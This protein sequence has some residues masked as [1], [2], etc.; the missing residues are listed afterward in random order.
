MKIVILA[1][2]GAIGVILG[3]C[4]NEI[5]VQSAALQ[6]AS[7]QTEQTEQGEVSRRIKILKATFAGSNVSAVVQ[8]ACDGTSCEL[9]ATEE[10][11][12]KKPAAYGDQNLKVFYT[13][14]HLNDGAFRF[15]QLGPDEIKTISC[16]N[17]EPRPCDNV[18][19]TEWV[20]ETQVVVAP[21]GPEHPSLEIPLSIV[22]AKSMWQLYKSTPYPDKVPAG[23]I[24]VIASPFAGIGA[25]IEF[26]LF[27][28]PKYLIKKFHY[29]LKGQ[30]SRVSLDFDLEGNYKRRWTTMRLNEGEPS[31]YDSMS[32][33]VIKDRKNK[34]DLPIN[35]DLGVPDE[36]MGNG[37]NISCQM[38]E[39]Q[40]G[41]DL[42][43]G[44]AK[45]LPPEGA[46]VMIDR[47]LS[48]EEPLGPFYFSC[49]DIDYNTQ[50]D[51]LRAKCGR[52][53]DLEPITSELVVGDCKHVVNDEGYLRCHEIQ[54]SDDGSSQAEASE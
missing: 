51:T 27:T 28:G 8:R 29:M 17:I 20:P 10:F 5:K 12:R 34:S 3:S 49:E 45:N 11:L 19:S 22:L 39:S 48:P 31:K 54:V 53:G 43:I 33:A 36:N 52:E 47:C 40:D 35:E 41:K 37:N 44:R 38:A 30:K 42:Y 7:N 32:Y 46:L 16:E 1:I 9:Q 2:M 25:G 50:T 23:A 14:L 21:Q 15:E 26:L 18:C 13:C 4:G 24:A 6:E